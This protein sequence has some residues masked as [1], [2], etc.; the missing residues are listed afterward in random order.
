MA[1]PE[2]FLDEIR[3]RV[4][5]AALIGRTVKLTRRGR[6]YTGLC[7]FHNEKSP[8]FTVN[9][10]KGFYHCFG[11]QEHGS[12]FDWVMKTQGLEFPEAVERLA[13][14]A[15]IPIPARDPRESQERD[16]RGRLYAALEEAAKWFAAQMES[17]RVGAAARAYVEQRGLDAPTVAKFQLGFAPDSRSALKQALL[18]RNVTEAT[19]VE[20]G[21]VIKPED[22][23]DTFDRFRDRL[24][25][26]IWDMRGRVVAFGGRALGDAHAKYL[27]SPE[28]SL[29]HKGSLLY[30]W[31]GARA[32][33]REAGTV[34]V[35]EGYMDVIALCRSGFSH[36]VAPLGTAVTEQQLAEL[37][38]MAPEPLIC[39]DGDKAGFQAALRAAHKALPFLQPGHSLRFALLGQGED[40]DSLVRK[41]KVAELRAALD[42]ALPLAEV[43]WRDLSSGDFSTPERRAGLRKNAGELVSEIREPTVREYYRRYFR[44]QLETAFPSGRQQ[45]PFRPRGP[46]QRS[47]Q[48]GPMRRG[49]RFPP[50]FEPKLPAHAGLGGSSDGTSHR[51][52]RILIAVLLRFPAVLGAVA[53]T[54]AGLNFTDPD[55]DSLYGRIIEIASGTSFLDGETLRAQLMGTGADAVVSSLTGLLDVSQLKDVAEAETLW[56]DVVALHRTAESRAAA[57]AVLAG[58]PGTQG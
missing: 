18:A 39:L 13:A 9:E 37:W 3:T 50:A 15:G 58:E 7:P 48:R 43:L 25:F 32:A 19:L 35:A 49:L 1:Y 11:C 46:D 14:D 54:R 17:Q 56:R 38:R 27:N 21:L 55:L 36:S 28:T 2:Q 52:E 53:E 30:N 44:E 5:L 31:P 8:S 22:G 41:G 6:E 29:F 24:M 10:D 16:E 57:Q 12:L 45:Q 33:A 26:P 51:R 47:G 34:I 40:P 42:K 23:G 4:P 20:T